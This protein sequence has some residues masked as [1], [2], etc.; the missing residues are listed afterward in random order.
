[1]KL[2]ET[3]LCSLCNNFTE[4]A[5]HLFSECHSTQ[6][7]WNKLQHW[8]Y[9]NI[10]LLQLNLQNA[11]LG[12]FEAPNSSDLSNY[13]LLIFKQAPYNKRNCSVIPNIDYIKQK[14][15][16]ACQK[17]KKIVTENGTFSKHLRKWDKISEKL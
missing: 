16:L 2:V 13:I 14:I 3:P 9:P 1:M 10:E 17:Q 5:I 12:F 15:R 11:M 6:T 4:S 8:L 7:P